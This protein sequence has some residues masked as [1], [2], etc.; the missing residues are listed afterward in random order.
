MNY[1]IGKSELI[2]RLRLWNSYLRRRVRLVACGGTAL[3][4]LGLKESTKDIDLMVPEA[5]EYD[6]LVK[7]LASIGYRQTTEHG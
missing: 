7:M 4:L 1:R 2:D 5:K 3:T 6:Y